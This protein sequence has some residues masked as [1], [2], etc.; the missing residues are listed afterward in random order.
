MTNFQRQLIRCAREIKRM[1]LGYGGILHACQGCPFRVD[2]K[3]VLNSTIPA[4]WE[5]SI[6]DGGAADGGTSEK[7]NRINYR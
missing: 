3:C 1:C 6:I 5:V 2:D 7:R 4:L